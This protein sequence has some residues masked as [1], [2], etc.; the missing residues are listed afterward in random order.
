MNLNRW[1]SA[2]AL[3]GMM[4]APMAAYTQ[5]QP[6]K[7][8]KTDVAGKQTEK[9]DYSFLNGKMYVFSDFGKH[10]SL[11]EFAI[12]A[13]GPYYTHNAEPWSLA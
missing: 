4:F 5:A 13:S 6:E 11:K 1:L 2:L 8:P 3:A 7:S 9:M 10:F 12:Q